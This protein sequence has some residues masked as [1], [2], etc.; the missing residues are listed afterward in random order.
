MLI[1]FHIFEHILMLIIFSTPITGLY[2]CTFL[3]KIH[4]NLISC[5]CIFKS[6]YDL[7][8]IY[9]VKLISITLYILLILSYIYIYILI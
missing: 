9:H 7:L 8:F 3:L 6:Y 4:H 5:E 2:L 1:Y